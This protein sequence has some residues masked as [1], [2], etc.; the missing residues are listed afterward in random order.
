[1]P[2]DHVALRFSR[3]S[4]AEEAISTYGGVRYRSKRHAQW[5]VF[6]D[7]LGLE[8]VYQPKSFR[9]GRGVSFT[10]DFW[11]PELNAWLVVKPTD[12]V[13]RD[14]DRWKVEHFVREYPEFRVWLSSGVPRAGEWHLE[15]LGQT[16][17]MRGMLLTDAS[18]PARRIW[19]C[20][21]N[22]ELATKLVFDA[23]EIGTGRSTSPRTCP[24]DPNMNSLMRMA[25]GQVDHFQV[26]SWSSL[27][28]VTG[29]L[30]SPGL[31][32]DASPM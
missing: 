7:A 29:R 25:Y 10:P 28:M 5:A 17:V 1:M 11:L 14:A 24:A 6:F 2:L 8:H 15:Q 19:V 21:A 13:I 26:D 9:L 3:N 32:S 20:G 27:G 23:I 31:R 4:E 30:A 16:P 18:E 22:D 12:A